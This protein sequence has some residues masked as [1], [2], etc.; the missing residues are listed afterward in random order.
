[1]SDKVLGGALVL[2]YREKNVK[3]VCF[4]NLAMWKL[5]L[6]IEKESSNQDL[7]VLNAN[8]FFPL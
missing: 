4:N 3:L 7:K 1:M 8:V 6:D 5:M 2:S